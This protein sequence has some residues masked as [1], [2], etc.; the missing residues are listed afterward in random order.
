M[1]F[2][3]DGL[4]LS[5]AVSKV[6]KATSSKTTSPI[7]EGI[8]FTCDGDYVTL[9]ATDLE[10]SIQKTIKAEVMGDGEIVVPG[11]LFSDYLRKLTNEKI[12]CSLELG[13]RL[14]IAYNESK[15]YIQCMDVLEFPAVKEISKNSYFE[16]SQKTL[17]NII[18]K[19]IFSVAV[20]D[21]KAIL[22][23]VLFEIE[24]E[25]LKAVA[26]DGYRLAMCSTKV[27]VQNVTQNVIVPGRSLQEIS[28]LLSDSDEMVRVYVDS[29]ILML[30]LGDTVVTTRLI[31]GQFI[32]Y[33][34]IISN[35]FETG[36]VIRKVQ[37]EDAI[38]RAS[39]LSK[40]DKNNLV[41]FD[42]RENVL[43]LTSN[44]EIG[45]ITE[46]ISANVDGNDLIIA[47]NSK[48]FSDCLHAIDDEYIKLNFVNSVNPCIVT[49]CEGGEY[50]YL[51]L[52]VR[53]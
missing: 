41:K 52:P 49:A 17:R 47:F 51:I 2:K 8:K 9:L 28:K 22:K 24:G 10:L 13:N 18:N 45:N 32:N 23:G 11:R 43:T 46:N 50:L 5:E 3:C 26:V 21:S 12:E 48:Y 14:K 53:I 33:K 38:E 31:E 35:N 7:L 15:G 39:I 42:I 40:I 6:I 44:S 1:Y 16:I 34:Q 25:N 20:D 37:L 19:V 29:N 4:D 27:K 36:V 30:D